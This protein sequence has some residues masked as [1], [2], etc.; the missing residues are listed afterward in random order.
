MSGRERENTRSLMNRF[1][2]LV[3]EMTRIYIYIYGGR[4][5]LGH[6]FKTPRLGFYSRF[7]RGKV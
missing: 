5:G 1:Q 7:N 2:D 3:D 4:S 6:H